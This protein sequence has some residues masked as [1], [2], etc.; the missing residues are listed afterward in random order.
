MFG[1]LRWSLLALALAQGPIAVECRAQTEPAAASSFL[2][3]NQE[4]LL[5]GSLRGQALLAEEEA[6]RDKL[7][8]EA[9]SI[10][11]AFEAEEQKLTESRAE[12]DPAEFRKLA[13]DFD[14]RVVAARRD[15]DARSAALA[16]EFDLRRRQ[17]YASV[18]PILVEVM[19]RHEA[20]AI[21][22]E[23]SVLLAAQELNITEEVIAEI[24]AA[25]GDPAPEAAEPPAT[26][27]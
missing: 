4:R 20:K 14:Q 23:N 25:P 16:S 2:L 7:R 18:A 5:T 26:T 12:L 1:G 9:R 3:V 8:A 27:E 15:Q 10:D 22:D 19:A 13:D 24:D 21:F 6:E 11:A 17:F